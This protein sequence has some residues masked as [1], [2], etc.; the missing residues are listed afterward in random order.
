MDPLKHEL[1][2]DSTTPAASHNH[3][4]RTVD[5]LKLF[6]VDAAASERQSHNHGYRTVDPL[7][8]LADVSRMRLGRNN[9]TTV[10]G[11]WTH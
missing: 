1:S 8:L 2:V 10:I 3:G 6:Q 4:Y 7:K 9:I 5:P 11:P